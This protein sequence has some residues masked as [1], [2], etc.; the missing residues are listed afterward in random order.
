MLPFLMRLGVTDETQA[1]VSGMVLSL[2]GSSILVSQ[3]LWQRGVRDAVSMRERVM[4]DRG[5][6]TYSIGVAFPY[7]SEYFLLRK[8]LRS[9]GILLGT[10][11]RLVIAAPEEMFPLLK[12]GYLD[13]YCAP[14][15]WA[16]IAVQAGMGACVSSGA[17]IA[18]MHPETVLMVREDFAKGHADRHERLI[19]AL[20]EACEFCETPRNRRQ[21]LPVLAKPQF[22]NAPATCLEPGLL[23]PFDLADGANRS[24]RC[25]NI[26]GERN[27]NAPTAGRADWITTQLR[28]YFQWRVRPG[29][30]NQVFRRDIFQRAQRL[31]EA[32]RELEPV[33]PADP[34]CRRLPLPTPSSAFA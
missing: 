19:A 22:V 15:P 18:P 1:C 12:L 9:S 14:E 32:Q 33:H 16:S 7:S 2:Q 6:R 11:V 28:D 31:V 30:L 10:D 3:E 23:G 27:A 8:W 25:L 24:L 34:R 26:F 29:S 4:L 21:L 5:S 17:G 20:L 13:G